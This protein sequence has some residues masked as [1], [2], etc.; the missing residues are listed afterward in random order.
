MNHYHFK[1]PL[2][3]HLFTSSGNQLQRTTTGHDS[4]FSYSSN[5][6]T[7]MH[8]LSSVAVQQLH[9]CLGT[10]HSESPFNHEVM[11][12]NDDM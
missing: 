10:S 12:N 4:F 11:V 2:I 3:R 9:I 8:E 5:T 6:T 1:L 7:P